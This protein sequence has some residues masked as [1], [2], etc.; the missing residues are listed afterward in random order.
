MIALILKAK[1]N[2]F[3]IKVTENIFIFCAMKGCPKQ[4]TT[5]IG[6]YRYIQLQ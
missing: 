3:R 5:I 4:C 2:T 1:F 6:N